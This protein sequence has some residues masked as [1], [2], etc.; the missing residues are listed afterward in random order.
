MNWIANAYLRILPDIVDRHV[1]AALLQNKKQH[2]IIPII[3][4]VY[5]LEDAS[6]AFERIDRGEQFGKFVL[7][8]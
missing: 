3:D 6:E 4:A 1:W 2:Q 5:G 8:I 7:A